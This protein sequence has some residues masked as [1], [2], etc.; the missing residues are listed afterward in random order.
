MLAARTQTTTTTAERGSN[1]VRV[2]DMLAGL[3]YALDLTEGQRPGHAVRSCLIGLRLA[4][5]IG[6][7]RDERSS[8]FYA[9]LMKD[10]G[11]SSNAA[12]FA[13]L[14]AADDHQLKADLKTVDWPHA[15]ASFRF[16]AASV[17]PGQAWPRR[18]WQALAVFARGPEG[19]REVVRTRCERG[20]DIARLLRF[21]DD[22]VQ[23]IR[24]IDEH[25]DGHGQPYEL[26]GDATPLLGRIV[27]LAQT[28]EVYFSTYGVGT[29]YDM[30]LARRGRWFDPD[31]VDALRTIRTDDA[32]WRQLQT[33]DELAQLALVEPADS[34][35][36]ADEAYLDLVAEAFARVID[37][38]S[39]WT[40]QH[41]NG[42]AEIAAVLSANLGFDA[43]SIREIRRAALLH[44]LGKLAVSNLILDKP[45]RLTDEEM[46][47]V[48]RH[49]GHTQQV[50]QRV[51]CFRHLA[52]MAASHHE[53][54]DGR[55]YHR[56]LPVNA[57]STPSRI[58][59]AA[60]ICDAL[61]ATRPY[62]PG[63]SADRILDIMGR[64]VGTG[65][66]ADCYAALRDVLLDPAALKED[67]GAAVPEVQR[68]AA[69]AEDYQQAA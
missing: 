5:V 53:R 50:L 66:D 26:K 13:A 22:T 12:R 20:A 19:A 11:C 30:A 61:R 27:G 39:P 64:E 60:D 45:G 10:L 24:T 46:A 57:L 16:V 33:G 29:A 56:G 48:K 32:L 62:R 40:Y 17:A 3:S 15:L 37:A 58:L 42:V 49:P 54:L 21:P 52:D 55:G 67:H 23:A 44:D 65:I 18:V 4:E 35:V 51:G 2:S 34:V 69:L 41:S 47:I 9:L 14:F 1:G 25:W 36:S 43:G 28:L 68:V 8:L 6:L 7:S 59:C 38:K 31:L 63:L